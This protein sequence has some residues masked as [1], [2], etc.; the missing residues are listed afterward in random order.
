MT[1]T[2]VCEFPLTGTAPLG[3]GPSRNQKLLHT[4]HNN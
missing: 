3:Y 1:L 4:R 2:G